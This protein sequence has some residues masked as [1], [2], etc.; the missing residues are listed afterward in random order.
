MKVLQAS[1]GGEIRTVWTGTIRRLI[2]RYFEHRNKWRAIRDD[3]A[4]NRIVAQFEGRRWCD[5]TEREL[6]G[7]ITNRRGSHFYDARPL[8]NMERK[9]L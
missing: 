9:F 7:D 8:S 4:E 5:A 2:R 3:S 6:I 1:S